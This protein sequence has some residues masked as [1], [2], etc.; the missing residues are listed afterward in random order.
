M[1][2]LYT[3]GNWVAK[4]GKE[5]EFIATWRE[6]AEW[7]K[8]EIRGSGQ[9]MLLR[10]RT[11]RRRFLSFGP[12]ESLGAIDVWRAHPGFVQRVTKLRELLETLEPRTLEVVAEVG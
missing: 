8:R 2:T 7:T 12:W 9:A 4:P 11:D 5:L 10:D 6:L 3:S 1:G